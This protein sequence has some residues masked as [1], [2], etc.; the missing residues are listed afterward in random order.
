MKPRKRIYDTAGTTFNINSSAQVVSVLTKL[1][2][3]HLIKYNKPT[4]AMLMKG[5]VEGNPKLDKNEME[6]L[7]DEGVPLIVDIMTYRKAQKLLNTFAIKLY[8]MMDFN[9]TV[10]CNINTMEAKTGRFS[11][12]APSRTCH[13]AKT[14]VSGEL[15]IA[16]EGATLYFIQTA[17]NHTHITVC[18]SDG[19][20]KQWR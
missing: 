16:P 4:E 8:E 19:H 18:V 12:S 20:Y 17:V 11:I 15:F 14:H 1:G 9:C 2:Y 3:G 5:T 7:E 6:R 10:H 13:D